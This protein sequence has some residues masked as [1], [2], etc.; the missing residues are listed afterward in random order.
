MKCHVNDVQNPVICAMCLHLVKFD[1]PIRDSCLLH[2]IRCHMVPHLTRHVLTCPPT[3]YAFGIRMT[4]VFIQTLAYLNSRPTYSSIYL[5]SDS[6][7]NGL[8]ELKNRSDHG[9]KF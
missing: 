1:V 4:T 8:T 6:I 5:Y 3:I 2:V 9:T 7:S